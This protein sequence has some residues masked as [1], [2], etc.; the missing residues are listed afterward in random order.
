MAT[1]AASATKGQDLFE[2]VDSFRAH[3]DA[4]DNT[5]GGAYSHRATEFSA[6][7]A[8]EWCDW[9][10]W[11]NTVGLCGSLGFK[12][13]N[14][15]GGLLAAGTLV[16]PS[17]YDSTTDRVLIVKADADDQT[18][19]PM[20]V[21][22]EAIDNNANGVAYRAAECENLNTSAGSVGDPVYLSGTAGAWTLTAPTTGSVWEVGVISVDHATT[23]SIKF[24]CPG[25]WEKFGSAEF[26]DTVTLGGLIVS[27]AT[28]DV[29]FKDTNASAGDVNAS[30]VVN[31]T[32]TGD[33]TEDVDVTFN[34][35]INGALTAFLTADADGNITMGSGR[36]LVADGGGSLT[37]TW[38]DLGSVTT[39][40]INGGTVD[41][42]TIGGASAGA[43]TFSAL[44]I[45]DATPD[46]EFKDAD[47][48]AGDVNASIVVNATDTGDGTEDVDVTFKQQVN[49]TLTAFLTADAD[50][51]LTFRNFK[52]SIGIENAN[53]GKGA[54]APAQVIL[55]NYNGWEYDISDDS[56]FTFHLPHD[57]ASSTD[58]TINFDWY[59]DEAYATN[60]GEVKW[61][62][63]WAATPHD[64]T[65]AVDAPTH[66]G[67]ADTGDIN[68]PATAKYLT[69][70]SVTISGAS[71]S[72]EDQIGITLS[73]IALTD[74]NNP[75][76]G[77][78]TIVDVHIEYTADKLGEAI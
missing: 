4:A 40:D 5:S 25:I 36:G 29:E 11:V 53:L 58:V 74:G 24:N 64:S 20:A 21:L 23:G 38:T 52:R 63:A 37:G 8:E 31:A 26:N 47:A 41:G 77:K 49:G 54:T 68:I 7:E 48:S 56:V 66:T 3:D 50:G 78:P 17:G 67:T 35:Q 45:S 16:Y 72:A 19:P 30:I 18:K 27:D 32:D 65:E 61:Q 34:Q 62:A 57:W 75:S 33:G 14:E 28:P 12:C 22:I 2:G 13:R 6:T 76:S 60:S 9:Y 70:D 71:L 43:G 51:G 1:V 39:V 15:T 73:R 59:I 42:A 44:T 55:G 10:R 69:E 46:V